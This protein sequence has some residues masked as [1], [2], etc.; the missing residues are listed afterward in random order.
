MAHGVR[1]WLKMRNHEVYS[2]DPDFVLI[3]GGDGTIL[4]ESAKWSS[5]QAHNVP[6]VRVNYGRRGFLANVEPDEIYGRLEDLIAGK[7]VIQHRERVNSRYGNGTQVNGLNDV[8]LERT[9]SQTISFV[10]K[11]GDVR[12]EFG[13]D[14]VIFAT[15]TGST[16]YNR[17][18]SGPIIIKNGYIVVNPIC[19]VDR[20][21]Y[22]VIPKGTV[23]TA[24]PQGAPARLVVDGARIA[25]IQ[26]GF[27]ISVWLGGFSRFVEFGDEQPGPGAG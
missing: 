1:A 27:S 12:K 10:V 26:P 9:G 21:Q 24:E 14:G 20:V 8:V 17:S 18:A 19:P 15:R 4:K 5:L 7:Y 11:Y 13:A 22:E 2:D 6:L 16:G 23:I 25:Q 3:F